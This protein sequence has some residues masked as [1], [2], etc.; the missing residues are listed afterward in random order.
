MI[1]HCESMSE[2]TYMHYFNC[3]FEL[4]KAGILQG[5]A[6]WECIDILDRYFDEA[7]S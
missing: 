4:R 2:A 3:L 1:L 5:E 7:N 6:Y